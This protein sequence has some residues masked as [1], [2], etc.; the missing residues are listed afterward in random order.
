L[1]IRLNEDEKAL[2]LFEQV[3]TPGVFDFNC[4]RLLECAQFAKR[5]DVAMR[6]CKE[7]RD[8]G[9]QDN[10][11][12]KL[13]LQLLSHYSPKQAYELVVEFLPH[14]CSY[15]TVIRNYLAVRLGKPSEIAFDEDYPPR[16][17]D[18]DA[19]EL[20]LV[21][22]PFIQ[23]GKYKDARNFLQQG[24]RA[25]FSNEIVHGKYIW[26]VVQHGTKADI[27]PPSEVNEE[28][29]IALK[30]LRTNE[31]RWIFIETNKPDKARNEFSPSTPFIKRLLG[32]KVGDQ[33]DI[34]E[35][36]VQQDMEEIVEIQSK[37]V[38]LFQ[39]AIS[40][41]QQRFPE[42]ASIQNVHIGSEDELD[43]TPL[44]EIA[45]HRREAVEGILDFYL[46]NPCSLFHVATQ[47][48]ITERKLMVTLSNCDQYNIQCVGFSPDS[49]LQAIEKQG[50][51]TA[52]VLDI[53]AIVTL[54]H[55]NAWESLDQ[56]KTYFVSQT[57]LELISTWVQ[58]LSQ[59]E[60]RPS[61][62]SSYTDDGKLLLQEITEEQ[63]EQELQEAQ[64]L[65]E[66]IKTLCIVKSS[67]SVAEIDPSRR[68]LYSK[69]CGH[70]TLEALSLAKD[71]DAVLWT[72]D[73]LVGMLAE[74][75]FGLSRA[76]T[77]LAFKSL[78]ISG[79]IS[80]EIY[81]ET[82]AKL[83]AWG[84]IATI[85]SAQ[86]IIAAGK[87]SGWDAKA[88]PLK[89]CIQ[90][91]NLSEMSSPKKARIALDFF[92]MLSRS[93]CLKIKQTAIIQAT[94]NA[95]NSIR[96]TQWILENLDHS[97]G[98]DVPSEEFY[99]LELAYWLNPELPKNPTHH[100]I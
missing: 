98:L 46:H 48:G 99:K 21:L 27:D 32:K 6:V 50:N 1:L 34:L 22:I 38:R 65:L 76:W 41:F 11:T 9:E 59:S 47:I 67:I 75:D 60:S 29:A 2:L 86:D 35:S 68:D 53:S 69:A 96:G 25:D 91:I 77:Q 73:R 78:E 16:L 93:D 82:T 39:D 49:F 5:H 18:F 66:E 15:Y 95:L 37:Y 19:P 58:E 62:Y 61:A 42:A 44:L 89:Q 70:H 79:K 13:E 24:L 97:F 90:L 20:D 8:T 80:S 30:N 57:T 56:D 45:K 51:S 74:A 28:S 88:W 7:L 87:L 4:K 3:Y 94:L 72:D 40:N 52:V 12:R 43:I 10:Q 14:D 26:F 71:E 84:Y 100:S 23:A 54:S 64:G 33:V 83:A 36:I 31:I 17:E 85:W 92:R 81:S 55:L 63:H